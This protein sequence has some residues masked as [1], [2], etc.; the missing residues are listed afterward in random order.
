MRETTWLEIRQDQSE[1]MAREVVQAER[2]ARLPRVDKEPKPSPY[3]HIDLGPYCDWSG[4]HASTC[5]HCKGI[6][7]PEFTPIGQWD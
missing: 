4:L 3:A 1:R 5:A 6:D 7:D 2:M